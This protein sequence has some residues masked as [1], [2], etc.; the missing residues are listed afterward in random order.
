MYMIYTMTGQY[1]IYHVQSWRNTRKL[2]FSL[3]YFGS[4]TKISHKR[5]VFNMYLYT[6]H[7]NCVVQQK[8]TLGQIAT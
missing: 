1:I 8:P 7:N 5:R 3:S 4:T 6:C 2:S